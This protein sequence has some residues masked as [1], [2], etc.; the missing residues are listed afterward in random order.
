MS[1]LK[2]DHRLVSA[3]KFL[4]VLMFFIF[5]LVTFIQRH[6]YNY[7]F[8]WHLS[9]GK[10]IVEQKSLP[11][12]DPF[13]YTSHEA[14][15]QRKSLILRGYWLAQV[16]FYKVFT[17]WSLKGIIM[18]RSFLMLLFLSFVF[19]TIKKEGASD[20]LSLI[21]TAGVFVVSKGFIGERPQLFT[22]VFFSITLY[23]LED[24][25]VNRSAK[26]YFVPAITLLLSNMHPGYVVCLMLLS[27]YLAVEGFLSIL[28]KDATARRFKRLFVV[29]V[30]AF[31]ASL[32]NPD[33]L[34]VFRG[35]TSMEK[36]SEAIVE[37][38][39]TLSV[40]FTRFSPIDYSYL[41]FLALSLLSL[42]YLKKVGLLHMAL[43]I[44]FTIMSFVAIRYL[45]FY[46]A[47]AA[48]I[49]ARIV[50]KIE[51]ERRLKRFTKF[52]KPKESLLY[53]IALLIGISLILSSIPALAKY[54]FREDTF[55]AT[56]KGAAD[57]LSDLR[58]G[59]NMF[60]EYGF[61][62]YLIW[63]LYPDKKVFIDGRSLEPDVYEDY[64]T[65][66]STISGRNGS[67]NDAL[68]KYAVTYIVMP[69]LM[70]GG[71]IYP[72]VEKLLEA[73]DWTLVYSDHLS[74][75]FLK[76]TGD[77]ASII[78]AFT[79]DRIEGFNTI[80]A[81]ASAGAIKNSTNPHYLITL[82]KVFLKMN[83]INNAKR[84]FEMAY[85]RDPN[86]PVIMEWLK[87]L[88]E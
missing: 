51:E 74:L 62:G 4:T 5:F 65:I 43:L 84:A 28:N 58:I 41:A 76:K 48:P 21:M 3:I 75:V 25:R 32:L 60:N 2:K 1:F 9:T 14:P 12:S 6:V 10:Y 87:K 53:L 50:M 82:G 57:F 29:W 34:G 20:L 47:I 77:N 8:W 22:F 68:N 26:I 38:M 63:R 49:L 61:G 36:H 40:Y 88:E 16:I 70:P 81:Q 71:D 66:A 27:L 23:L 37:F 33:G 64:K 46:M 18:L 44:V 55:F 73:D 19:L 11:Q 39:P 78:R 80:I 13:A 67:W 42:C 79:K 30:L 31:L 86:N 7:D 83:K 24:F 15:T 85:R 56:P 72:I 17:L 59:G 69:P 35:F 45:I 54:E 52:L